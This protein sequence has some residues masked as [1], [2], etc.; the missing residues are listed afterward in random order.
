M[1]AAQFVTRLVDGM[2]PDVGKA[3]VALLRRLGVQVEVPLQQTCCGQMPVNTGYPREALPLVRNHVKAFAGYD[4]IVAPSG[5]CAASIRHQHQSSPGR[6]PT[7]HWLP[8]PRRWLRG[9][10]NC[11]SSSA[12]YWA[13]EMSART[14]RTVLPI[15]RRATRAL[16]A[17]GRPAGA[18]AARGETL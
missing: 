3:T 1:K 13:C 10:T 7:K 5:S 2:A 9:P 6:R 14:S 8:P 12:T 15:T 17:G 4:V 18:D 11:R 16:A